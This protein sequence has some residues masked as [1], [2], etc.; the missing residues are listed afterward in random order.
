MPPSQ[1]TRQAP[2]RLFT[3]TGI[4]VGTLLGSLIAAVAMI[5]FNYRVLGYPALGNRIAAA[6]L[7]F[8]LMVITA[9]SMAPNTPALGI[10]VML[11]QC[12]IAWWGAKTLQGDAIA[13]HVARGGG[14][15]GL[16]MAGLVGLATGIV[17]VA[18]MLLLGRVS[19]LPIGIG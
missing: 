15:H 12:A 10:A 8:Y 17:A 9:A 14:V 3:P 7:V 4:L 2:L 19:G 16:G 18:I 13:Y 6:G 5:W 1:T 11:G